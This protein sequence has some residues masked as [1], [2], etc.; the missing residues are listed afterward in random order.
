MRLPPLSERRVSYVKIL[1]AGTQLPPIWHKLS[2][3]FSELAG[4]LK[5]LM[6]PSGSEVRSLLRPSWKNGG[7]SGEAA[8]ADYSYIADA[9]SVDS[10]LPLQNEG[11][12]RLAFAAS[13]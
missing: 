13:C 5:H 4:A 1:D 8:S 12:P 11:P 9:R 7:A 10:L 2:L 3:A 6:D